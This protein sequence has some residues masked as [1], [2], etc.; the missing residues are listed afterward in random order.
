MKGFN[1]FQLKLIMVVLMVI[2][3]VGEFIPGSPLWFRYIGRLAAPV[4]FYLLVEGFVYTR[5]RRRY[6]ERLFI[7]GA[8]MLCGSTILMHIFNGPQKIINNIFLSMGVNIVMLSAIEWI[9]KK[10]SNKVLAIT[11]I[12]GSVIIAPFTEGGL[13]IALLVLIF[14]Y[15]RENKVKMSI[16]YVMASFLAL[17]NPAK[18]IYESLFITNYQW[19]MVFALPFM[20]MYNGERGKKAKYFFYIFYPVHI[21]VLYVLGN[22][23]KF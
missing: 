8:I 16:F 23:I 6:M 18:S 21:W 14:Y 15:N 17:T 12:I 1:G 9:K 2:D 13:F 20:L 5:S 3:H 11:I 7:G 10:D 4:F 19:M 22:Y